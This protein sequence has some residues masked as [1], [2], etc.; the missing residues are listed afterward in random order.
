MLGA[1]SLS[2]RGTRRVG[3]VRVRGES[4]R[5]GVGEGTGSFE[6]RPWRAW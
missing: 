6:A 2:W 5:T 3:V 4:V 1:E